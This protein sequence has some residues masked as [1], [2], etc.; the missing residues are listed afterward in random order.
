MTANPKATLDWAFH[1]AIVGR[2]EQSHAPN[3]FN[4]KGMFVARRKSVGVFENNT[5]VAKHFTHVN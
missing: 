2:L 3:N 4:K 1:D 5:C